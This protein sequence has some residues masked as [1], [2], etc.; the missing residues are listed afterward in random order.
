MSETTAQDTSTGRRILVIGGGPAAH[1]FVQSMLKRGLGQD[2]ITVLSEEQ[3]TPYDRVALEKLFVDA[4]RDLTLGDPQMWQAPGI[5]LRSGQRAAELDV[6]AR[7]VLTRSGETFAYD[8]LVLATGS[9][10]ATLNI[11]G[12]HRVHV[13]RTIDD[14]R[15]IVAEVEQLKQKLGRAPRGVVV[16]GGL[17]GLEAAAGLLDLGAEATILDVAEFLLCTQMDREGGLAVNSL[18]REQGLDVQC[19]SYIQGVELDE[20]ENVIG[21]NVADG[22]GPEAV[23]RRL[24]AD[25]VILGVGIRPRSGLARRSGFHLDPRG[26]VVVDEACRTS[27]AHV[28]AIG[29][30]A[31]IL[32]QTWGLVG[33]ANKMAEVVADRLHGGDGEVSGFDTST[34][35]KFAG[36]DVASFGDVYATTPGAIEVDYSD[37]VAGIYQKLVVAED[38]ETLIGGVFVGNAEPYDALRPLQGRPL[39]AEPA[40]YLSAAGGDAPETELP[41]DAIL[42]SCNGVPFGEIRQAVRDGHQSVPELKKCTDAG[43][44]CG[45]C[46]PMMH[47]TLEKTMAEMGLTVSKALCEHFELSRAELYAAVRATGIRT[48]PEALERFG[49]GQDGCAICKPTMASIL[50]SQPHA[51]VLDEGRGTL[52]DTND[53]NLGN[54]QKDGTYSV[55]PRIP[56]GEITPEKLAVIAEVGHEYGLYTKITGAQRIGLYGARLEELPAIWKRFVDAG[57]ESGQA[58]GKSLRNVK[59]CLGSTWCRY[60]VQDSVGMGI[61]LE[62]RYRG[63]RSPHKFK[64][65]SSGCARDCAESQSKDIGVM[66]TPEGWTLY[67]GGNGGANPAHGRVFAESVSEAELVQYVDRYLMYYIRTADK[68]QRTARWLE[69]LDE[70]YGD[71][72]VHLKAVLIDDSLGICA[73]LEADMQRQVEGYEDEWAATLRDPQRLRRFRPFVNDP[74]ASD[75]SARQYVLEREQIRPATPEE[76]AAAEDGTGPVLISGTRIPVGAQG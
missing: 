24:E 43:T 51:Y 72:I 61:R 13:F 25:M 19:S 37:P 76:I 7:T 17:L 70:E 1:R 71:G 21:V 68:L 56:G 46:V 64:I 23:V 73:D 54:L 53:R 26:G 35:L 2:T 32:G 11:P 62:N 10:A 75:D 4:E 40:R 57:F 55:V 27:V 12:A 66:A 41:D 42:C 22:P 5:E 50:A 69:D 67:L 59:S 31:H 9:N 48:F 47:K 28:W 49:R 6:K 45:S 18:M 36:V 30:V 74:D 38:R 58:Y 60:G 33:P 14:V 65:G 20:Q 15:G 39:P 44:Q 3:W 16:G 34:R 52:Q 8:E 29:E 63:L